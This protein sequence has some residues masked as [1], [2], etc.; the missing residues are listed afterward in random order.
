VWRR[1]R[2]THLLIPVQWTE[3][4]EWRKFGDVL[5]K[6]HLKT[7]VPVVIQPLHSSAIAIVEICLLWDRLCGG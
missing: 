6:R 2:A 3:T 4:L 7:P 1:E 5:G